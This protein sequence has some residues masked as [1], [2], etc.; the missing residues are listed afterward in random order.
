MDQS[1]S[2]GGS[3]PEERPATEAKG[4]DWAEKREEA[5]RTVKETAAYLQ[6]HGQKTVTYLKTHGAAAAGAAA[7]TSQRTREEVVREWI[8]S[9]G[10]GSI[11]YRSLVPGHW[12]MPAISLGV[13]WE[14]GGRLSGWG[15]ALAV[16]GRGE[17]CAR[18][19]VGS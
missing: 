19:A 9:T 18:H 17:G 7:A 6:E 8:K 14:G 13:G 2:L 12:R 15:I 1:V 4:F 10:L 5:S 16:L 3:A 11:V